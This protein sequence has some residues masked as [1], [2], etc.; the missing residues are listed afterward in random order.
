MNGTITATRRLEFDAGHRVMN[1]ESKCRSVHGHRYVA[2][3]TFCSERLDHCGRVLDYGVVK[4]LIGSWIDEHLDH[5]YLHHHADPIGALLEREGHKTF[6]MPVSNVDGIA[7]AL[8]PTAECI[9]AM[10]AWRGQQLLDDWMAEDPERAAFRVTISRVKV[11]ETPNC[12]AEYIPK[13]PPERC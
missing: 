1:H 6:P 12:S 4:E 5:G 7:T 2:E 13:L 3:I 10:L 8:E 9:A 11:W